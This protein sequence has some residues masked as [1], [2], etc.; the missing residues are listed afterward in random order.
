M[1]EVTR[2]LAELVAELR[3]LLETERRAL[4]SGS[5]E[6]INDIAQRKMQLADL[7]ERETATAGAERPSPDTLVAIARYNRENGI[8]CTAM[9]RHLTAS[10]DRLRRHDPHRSYL[11]DGREQTL[12]AQHAL[13]AA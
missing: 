5:P 13:G 10:I 6:A 7:I 1:E 3:E 2:P 8:I 9:L 4:L 11:S 12:S